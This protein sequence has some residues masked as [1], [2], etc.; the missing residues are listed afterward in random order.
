MAG[1][2]GITGGEGMQG[3][4]MGPAGGE[5]GEAL[6]FAET[7]QK[8][9]AGDLTPNAQD[10]E[11]GIAPH[12]EGFDVQDAAYWEIRRNDWDDDIPP[13]YVFEAPRGDI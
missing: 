10:T 5:V 2:F 9:G 12:H 3:M 4:G 8:P 1:V 11:G 13:R 7:L 6:T